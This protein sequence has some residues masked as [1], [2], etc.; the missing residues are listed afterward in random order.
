MKKLA[1]LVS[2]VVLGGLSVMAQGTIQFQNASTFPIKVATGTDA[3]SLAAATVIGSNATS[4][5]L[6]AG[7]GQ[8]NV[9]MYVSL[10]SAPTQ[11]FLAGSTT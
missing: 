8:V 6:G 5:S 2:A 4:V 1:I 3:A 7:L 11:F 9:Q 10:A